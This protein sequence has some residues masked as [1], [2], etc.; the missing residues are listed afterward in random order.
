MVSVGQLEGV[1]E[2]LPLWEHGG[3]RAGARM[4]D[5][6]PPATPHAAPAGFL[7]YKQLA[8]S[9]IRKGHL[10][11]LSY[12][13]GQKLKARIMAVSSWPASAACQASDH[14]AGAPQQCACML[15]RPPVWLVLQMDMQGP[16][17]EIILSEKKAQLSQTL[18][19][20]KVR[21]KSR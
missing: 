10:G 14:S 12:L 16:K 21:L 5:P 3:P 18:R 19:R 17:R 8:N 13:V 20:L 4:I 9:T 15:A 2:R 7:P 11:D 6:A 1:T